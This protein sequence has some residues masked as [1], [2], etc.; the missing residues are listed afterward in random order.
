MECFD[1]DVEYS[2]DER[3]QKNAQERKDV[4]GPVVFGAF[5]DHKSLP[6]TAIKTRGPLKHGR[7][8]LLEVHDLREDI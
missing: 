1:A 5:S 2:Q 6:K 4:V 3:A 8:R 7:K